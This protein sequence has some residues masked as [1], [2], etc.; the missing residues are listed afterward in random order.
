[1]NAWRE[2]AELLEQV[3]HDQDAELVRLEDRWLD[4]GHAYLAGLVDGFQQ[5]VLYAE[6]QAQ[7][8]EV[9]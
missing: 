1:M 6:R 8:A 3:V 4:Q 9:A 7:R 5:G 2:A